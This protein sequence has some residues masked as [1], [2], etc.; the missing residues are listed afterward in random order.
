MISGLA[1]ENIADPR[2]TDNAVNNG[3]KLY[4]IF[5]QKGKFCGNP[6]SSGLSKVTAYGS[7]DPNNGGYGLPPPMGGS[8]SFD[9]NE[10]CKTGSLS[11]IILD[12]AF[13]A[14]TLDSIRKSSFSPAW[15]VE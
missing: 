5:F 6:G 11:D 12:K 9:D 8:G 7:R 13:D 2:E 3:P 15:A 4:T 1:C 14:W 10:R